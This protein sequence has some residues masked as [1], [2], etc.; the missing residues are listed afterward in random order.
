MR[1]RR[2]MH[3]PPVTALANVIAQDKTLDQGA[4]VAELAVKPAGALARAPYTD[5][6]NLPVFVAD[7]ALRSRLTGADEA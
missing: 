6:D 7:P 2:M 1:F 3:Y 4:R 5:G